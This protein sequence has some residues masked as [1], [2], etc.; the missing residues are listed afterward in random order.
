MDEIIDVFENFGL[1]VNEFKTDAIL[2]RATRKKFDVP[3][4][5]IRGSEIQHSR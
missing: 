2:F 1:K 4:V 5:K 3:K